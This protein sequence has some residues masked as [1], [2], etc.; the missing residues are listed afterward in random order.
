MSSSFL[1]KIALPHREVVYSEL[2]IKHL[3]NLQKSLI[4]EPDF[5]IVILNINNILEEITN[6]SKEEIQQLNV[7]DYFIILSHIRS[8]CI[9][10]VVYAELTQQKN[11]KLNI[12]VD[13]IIEQLLQINYQETLN[14]EHI[15]KNLQIN[16]R[17][18]T[19][20][21]LP[22]LQTKDMESFCQPFIKSLV[23][24]KTEFLFSDFSRDEKNQMIKKI[25]AKTIT[26]LYKKIYNVL[27][28]YAKTN[29]LDHIKNIDE[30]ISFSF[31]SKSYIS[32]ISLLYGDQLLSIY[33][34]IFLLCK[35]GNFTPD[36]LENCT[37]GEY[38]IFCRKLEMFMAKKQEMQN[39]FENNL[40][41]SEDTGDTL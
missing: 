40:A 9:S 17:L 20:Q 32:L 1:Y 11:V 2:K 6:L 31:N 16:Y 8:T 14:E 26:E 38:Y 41:P 27:E 30:F 22:Y 29:L 13:E 19:P 7:V 15:N 28:I 21:E 34:N 18:P 12:N 5:N 3:K 23:I 4:G 10:N 37:P 25:P 35:F 24:N 39:Q 36:Y 33:D